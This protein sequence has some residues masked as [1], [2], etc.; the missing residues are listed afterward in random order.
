MYYIIF[1][2]ILVYYH[3]LD[4]DNDEWVDVAFDMLF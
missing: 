1:I 2:G 3:L 4:H